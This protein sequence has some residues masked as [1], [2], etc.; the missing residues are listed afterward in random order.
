[1][2]RAGWIWGLWPV[3]L[4]LIAAVFLHS[5]S[6]AEVLPL[7]SSLDSFPVQ[8]GQWDGSPL[9]IP[10]S[11]LAVLGPGHFLERLYTAPGKPAV[12][13]F[14]AYFPVQTTGDL[15]HSPKHC[16]PGAGWTPVNSTIISVP[17]GDG[18]TL[19]ANYYVLEMGLNKEV[20]VYWF[21]SHGRTVASEYW[22]KF[23][24]VADA[25]RMNRT[26]GAMV[27]VITQVAQDETLPRAKDRA[28]GFTRE[29]LPML[30][31]YIPN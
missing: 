10:S 15:I 14:L 11:A 3:I 20:V 23:Y 8:I 4:L 12:D 2:K 19:T 26:D 5:R 6:H 21:Q 7:H 29:I 18:Q 27:R 31:K 13:L 17:W 24:L 25:L 16:L 9:T 28:L 30:H 22:V 1:M